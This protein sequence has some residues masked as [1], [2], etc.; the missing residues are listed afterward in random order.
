MKNHASIA[1][2]LA[3][4]S[5]VSS[6]PHFRTTETHKS[7][8]GRISGWNNG[9]SRKKQSRNSLCQCGS[10]IKAKKCCVY[11]VENET[12]DNPTA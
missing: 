6:V 3:V 11:E 8:G 12:E 9:N 5:G 4:L 2:A 7:I 1:A 10:G